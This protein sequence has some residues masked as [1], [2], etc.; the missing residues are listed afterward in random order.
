MLNMVSCRSEGGMAY[1][2]LEL[3]LSFGVVVWDM[4]VFVV[5]IGVPRLQWVIV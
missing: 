5:Q 3:L 2:A 1:S 4:G